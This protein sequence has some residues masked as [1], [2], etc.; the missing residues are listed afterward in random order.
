MIHRTADGENWLLCYL[1]I[2]PDTFHFPFQARTFDLRTRALILTGNRNSIAGHDP[3]CEV[4]KKIL[5]QEAWIS[6]SIKLRVRERKPSRPK[7][8]IARLTR[9]TR[10]NFQNRPFEI[11]VTGTTLRKH[12]LDANRLS[13][14]NREYFL[15]WKVNQVFFSKTHV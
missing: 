10:N 15:K 13:D 6:L 2:S 11:T 9:N 1:I 3:H 8:I 4:K 14:T 12:G 7:V 5:L